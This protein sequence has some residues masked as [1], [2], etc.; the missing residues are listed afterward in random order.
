MWGPGLDTLVKT[1]DT[2]LTLA[3]FA[4][5]QNGQT[6]R[7]HVWIKDEFTEVSSRDTFQVVYRSTSTEVEP[8]VRAMAF[9]LHQNFPNPFNPSTTISFAIGRAAF[10]RLKVYDVLGKEVATLVNETK[11]AG[12][13]DVQWNASNLPSGV[14]FYQLQA[15]EFSDMKKMALIR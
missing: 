3:P 9:R 10:V 7:W 5:M 11:Q 6:Y 15:G 12:T 4:S 13:Y 1:R 14:Y 8:E 2:S